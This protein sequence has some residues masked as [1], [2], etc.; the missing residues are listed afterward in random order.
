MRLKFICLLFFIGNQIVIFGQDGAWPGQDLGTISC[1]NTVSVSGNTTGANSDCTVSS[2][3]DHIYQF[4][5]VGPLD[6]TIT[7]CNS[8]DYDTELHLFNLAN[9]NCN[10][11]AIATNDDSGCIGNRSTITQTGLASGSY[12]VI[13][14]GWNANEGNYQLDITLSNCPSVISSVS[15]GGIGTTN[16]TAWFKADNLGSGNLTSWTTAYPTGASAITV[17]DGTAPYSQV[18]T[19]PVNNIFNYNTVADF[20]GNSS[21]NR[22]YITNTSALNLL[23]NQNAGSS[24]TFL[25]VYARAQ[26]PV[27]NDGIV[28]FK[29]G[30]HG[31][32]LRAW[33]RLAL[34]KFNSTNG[35]RN[36][37]PKANLVPSIVGYSGNKSGAGTMYGVQNDLEIT[38]SSGSSA[39]MKNGLTF[40]AKRNGNTSYNEYFDGYISEVVFF[41]NTLGVADINKVNSYLAIKYGITLENTGG[42]NQGDYVSAAGSLIW[43]AS[44][45]S[46]YHNNIIGIGKEESQG[47]NQKQS[48]SFDDKIRVYLN[49]LETTNSGNSGVITDDNSYVVIGSNSDDICATAASNVEMPSGCSLYSR[50]AREWKLTKTNFDQSFNIDITLDACGSAGVGNVSDLRLLVDTDGNFANGGS[51]CYE[52]GDGSGIVISYTAPVITVSGLTSTHFGNNQTSFFTIGSGSTLTPLPVKLISFD[53]SCHPQS[54]QLLSWKTLSETNN[55]YFIIEKSVDGVFWEQLTVIKGGGTTSST[56]VYKYVDANGSDYLTYY[57]LKQVDFDGKMTIVSHLKL[58]C[59]NLKPIIYPN[60]FNDELFIQFKSEGAYRVLVRDV[61]GQIVY[62]NEFIETNTSLHSIQLSELLSKGIYYISIL[63]GEN[64]V[65]LNQKIIKS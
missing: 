35:T 4:T 63:K 47:L 8:A 24:G 43:D 61:L 27:Q 12:A 31:I 17:S 14:E 21:S 10:A 16:L 41:S 38:N 20:A 40:G 59:E 64:T 9:G 3:G 15:P 53:G 50:L 33:G 34:G 19:T 2:A 28:T 30:D 54:G 44:S 57:R 11:G 60:P 46:A 1:P 29:N 18:S 13:V 23:T 58:E 49:S 52:T 45:N 6:I 55:D 39:L 22:K 36:F 25:V 65:V 5:I 37:T 56:K 32:Q 26:S 51:N 42:G 7:T 48:H 62:K